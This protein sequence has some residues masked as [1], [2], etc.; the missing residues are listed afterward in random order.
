MVRLTKCFGWDLSV[1]GFTILR[2]VTSLLAMERRM[3]WLGPYSTIFF[4]ARRR[5][6]YGKLTEFEGSPSNSERCESGRIGV[7]ANDLTWETGSV[8]SNPTL[9]ARLPA[10][11][12]CGGAGVV[13]GPIAVGAQP[14]VPLLFGQIP[15]VSDSPVQPRTQTVVG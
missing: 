12:L 13:L 8:G 1:V 10:R 6:S 4:A 14:G 5:H 7:T 9:S 11:P 3:R 2:L 15:R